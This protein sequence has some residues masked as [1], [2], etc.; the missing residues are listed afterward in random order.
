MN[1][2]R[3]GGMSRG[4]VFD[5]D[6]KAVIQAAVSPWFPVQT[7]TPPIPSDRASHI[8]ESGAAQC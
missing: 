6:S 5:V 2:S 4:N 3:F 7:L 1:I 8:D